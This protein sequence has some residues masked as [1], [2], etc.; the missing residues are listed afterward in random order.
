MEKLLHRELPNVLVKKII[1]KWV[2]QKLLG[3]PPSFGGSTPR[4]FVFL[5]RAEIFYSI[6]IRNNLMSIL[7]LEIC[8]VFSKS[9][10]LDKKLS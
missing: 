5:L 3:K 6:F 4:D 7:H 8:E 2:P 1:Q 9:D 10:F